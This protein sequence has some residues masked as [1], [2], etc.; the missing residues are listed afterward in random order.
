M[1]LLPSGAFGIRRRD[2]SLHRQCGG[3]II[4]GNKRVGFTAGCLWPDRP[5][6]E[7]LII[8][9]WGPHSWGPHLWGAPI[10]CG[11]RRNQHT[12]IH[13]TLTAIRS[14][15]M[16]PYG[17]FTFHRIGQD[18]HQRIVD[19]AADHLSIGLVTQK[20]TTACIGTHQRQD[21]RWAG[22]GGYGRRVRWGQGDR[23]RGCGSRRH[24][25]WSLSECGRWCEGGQGSG[26]VA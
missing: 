15:N 13:P 14:E 6:I 21:W 24:R 10:R 2:A 3:G 25:R 18:F 4:D 12:L 17:T 22:A 7:N 16:H 23:R 20:R 19:Q 9:L 26:M 11:G 8:T 1:R 5:T